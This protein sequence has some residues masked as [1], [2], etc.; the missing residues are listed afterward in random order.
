MSCR[1]LHCCRAVTAGLVVLV[2]LGLSAVVAPHAA[3]HTGLE[4]SEPAEGAAAPGP[5]ERVVL[6]FAAAV[7][8]VDGG[9]QLFD[10][11]GAGL[12]IASVDQPEPSRLEVVPAAA[13]ADGAY[14]LRWSTRAEDGHLVDGTVSFSAAAAPTDPGDGAG[15]TG[16]SP[17][18][19][20]ADAADPEVA[21][22]TDTGGDGAAGGSPEDLDAALDAAA[23]STAAASTVGWAARA[24]VYAGVLFSIGGIV[25]LLFVHEGSPRETRRIVHWIRRAAVVV[26]AATGL[27]GLAMIARTHQGAFSAVAPPENWVHTFGGSSGLGLALAAGGGVAILLGLRMSLE[28]TTRRLPL[29]RPVPPDPDAGH[30]AHGLESRET[31]DLVTDT[32]HGDGSVATG[33]VV[34]RTRLT[35]LRLADSRPGARGGRRGPGVVPVPR[36]HGERGAACPHRRQR[37]R[38]RG[39]GSGVVR[40]CRAARCGVVA[41]AARARRPA[42]RAA[43]GAVRP[44]G[45]GGDPRGGAVRRAARR[46]HRAVALRALDHH[47]RAAVGGEGR[48]RRGSDGARRVQPLPVRARP[49]GR[50]AGPCG[51]SA[52]AR[53]GDRR[54]GRLRGGG[55]VDGRRSSR[56]ARPERL[57]PAGPW[58]QPKSFLAK[59]PVVLP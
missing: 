48:R 42:R 12:D 17:P 29:D 27:Q 21:A 23:P 25:Y 9:M 57:T 52:P 13:L 3:A 50:P 15:V 2:A 18:A 40:W 45:H 53:G 6:R 19:G 1:A 5:V 38:P 32:D 30:D 44:R 49:R 20:R 39:R 24:L 58:L 46:H 7:A 54:D 37:R 55:G 8:P 14:G 22:D 36:P 28:T 26:V 43:R 56:R 41:T 10:G 51:G 59:R 35:K 11:D 47:L 16:E 31:V 34:V 4:S 33:Q